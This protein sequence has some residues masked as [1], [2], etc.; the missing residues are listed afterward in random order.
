M[1]NGI[2]LISFI[3]IFL[4]VLMIF[5]YQQVQQNSQYKIIQQRLQELKDL[6]MR[7]ERART[8]RNE[9]APLLMQLEIIETNLQSRK[10]ND[11]QDQEIIDID[12]IRKAI[13]SG[14]DEIQDLNQWMGPPFDFEWAECLERFPRIRTAFLAAEFSNNPLLS[15][16]QVQE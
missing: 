9:R 14:N 2:S 15:S 6:E 1:D 12:N 10:N 13:K 5:I 4:L 16:T 8:L 11:L 7:G 3:F